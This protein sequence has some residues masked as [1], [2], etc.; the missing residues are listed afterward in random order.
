MQCACI[1]LRDTAYT[2]GG[3]ISKMIRIKIK[4]IDRRSK[5]LTG[6]YTYLAIRQAGFYLR[7]V[8]GTTSCCCKPG[9]IKIPGAECMGY[10]YRAWMGRKYGLTGYI[11]L[12]T[13]CQLYTVH[14]NIVFFRREFFHFF[15]PFDKHF[16]REFS[17]GY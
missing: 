9:S 7:N 3:T 10:R 4:F 12:L 1:F 6:C 11:R 16:K 14:R 15:G 17:L 2:K 5:S 8:T 13:S